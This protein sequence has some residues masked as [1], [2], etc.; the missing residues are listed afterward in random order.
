MGGAGAGAVLGPGGVAA[1]ASSPKPAS[2]PT[3]SLRLWL[4]RRTKLH[5]ITVPPTMST[6]GIVLAVTHSRYTQACRYFLGS[7]A[8]TRALPPAASNC[9]RNRHSG[10]RACARPL[11]AGLLPASRRLYAP[12]P[13]SPALSAPPHH[14]VSFRRGLSRAT[15]AVDPRPVSCRAPKVLA[16]SAPKPNRADGCTIFIYMHSAYVAPSGRRSSSE[17]EAAELGRRLIHPVSIAA[18]SSRGALVV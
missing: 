4:W 9:Q 18:A 1:A 10:P 3:E 15:V 8:A 5:R 13:P 2:M 17:K 6:V 7:T 11:L 14:A 16:P 12:P